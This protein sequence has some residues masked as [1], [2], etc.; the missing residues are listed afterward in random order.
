MPQKKDTETSEKDAS[1]SLK[2]AHL[3]YK[4]FKK[5]S[6]ADWLAKLQS[7]TNKKTPSDEQLVCVKA[8][9]DRCVKEAGE[10]NRNVEYRSEPLRMIL[11]GVPGGFLHYQKKPI[12]GNILLFYT[13]KKSKRLMLREN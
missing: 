1:K 13:K 12:K 8:I 2:Q 10:E 9:I 11:H 7:K 3:L 4:G 5:T 6:I